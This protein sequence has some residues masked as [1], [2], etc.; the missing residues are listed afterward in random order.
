MKNHDFTQKNHIFFNVRG[1]GA[2]PPTPL[3]TPLDEIRNDT[4]ILMQMSD[5]QLWWVSHKH[6][7]KPWC[8]DMYTSWYWRNQSKPHTY[9]TVFNGGF[10]NWLLLVPLLR[11]L[12]LCQ[13]LV[14]VCRFGFLQK[15]QLYG[16]NSIA[17]HVPSIYLRERPF[18]LKAG[19]GGGS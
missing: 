2:P 12:Q 5:G 18:N 9:L 10:Q 16:Q 15:F 19:V 17:P 13:F 14:I 6:S 11:T 3:D 8:S 4:E 1:A 7:W